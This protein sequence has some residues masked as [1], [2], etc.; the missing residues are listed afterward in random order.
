MLR[1]VAKLTNSFFLMTQRRLST[2]ACRVGIVLCAFNKNQYF[3]LISSDTVDDLA[4]KEVHS[5]QI[6]KGNQ[7]MAATCLKKTLIFHT[8]Q[9]KNGL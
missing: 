1:R 7:N 6:S 5:E 8:R 2:T 3:F 9:S 4:A